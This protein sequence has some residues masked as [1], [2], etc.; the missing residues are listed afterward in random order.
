MFFIKSLEDKIQCIEYKNV[1]LVKGK[2]RNCVD[3]DTYEK[4]FK[5]KHTILNEIYCK[6]AKY[7]NV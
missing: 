7:K 1:F 4:F 3:R 6:I 5:K 2:W